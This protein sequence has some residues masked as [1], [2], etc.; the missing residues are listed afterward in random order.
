MAQLSDRFRSKEFV[1]GKEIFHISAYKY[2]FKRVKPESID[3]M[4]LLQTER[5]KLE[6]IYVCKKAKSTITFFYTTGD[7][8]LQPSRVELQK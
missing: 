5:G 7:G 6:V 3:S 4:K 8:L 2:E 1:P